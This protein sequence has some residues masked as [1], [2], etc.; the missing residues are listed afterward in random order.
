MFGILG[1]FYAYCVKKKECCVLKD[2]NIESGYTI[3]NKEKR[4]RRVNGNKSV[5]GEEE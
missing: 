3:K 1:F 5:S 4:K 2:E